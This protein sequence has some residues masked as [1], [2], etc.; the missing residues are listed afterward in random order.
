MYRKQGT[1]H[2]ISLGVAAFHVLLVT[3]SAAGKPMFTQS[4]SA[5]LRPLRR[6]EESAMDRLVLVHS[7]TNDRSHL[8]VWGHG[9]LTSDRKK[10][11]RLCID[12]VSQA[13]P[14]QRKCQLLHEEMA[15]LARMLVGAPPDSS[16]AGAARG[17][18]T[19]LG[20][21]LR[22]RLSKLQLLLTESNAE[23]SPVPNPGVTS[24]ILC[25]C[26]PASPRNCATR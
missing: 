2:L 1:K 23:V 4:G 16:A 13:Q 15:E 24:F 8:I 17:R 9:S 19:E 22:R 14:L 18:Q 21:R 7:H 11:A 26:L 5:G 10:A 25:I 12:F 20:Y 3:Y 6:H